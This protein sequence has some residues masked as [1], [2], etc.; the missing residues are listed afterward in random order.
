MALRHPLPIAG[1]RFSISLALVC[2]GLTSILSCRTSTLLSENFDK[3]PVAM[4]TAS[5]G[6]FHTVNG[7][8]VD[9]VGGSVFGSLCHPPASGNCIDLDGTGGK[10]Q[11]VLQSVNPFML[12]PGM[13]YY[14]SFNLIGSQRGN[15]T[16]TTVTF[17]P[18]HRTFVLASN[19]DSS[20]IVRSALVA[21]NVRTPAFLT[22][23]S[24]TPGEMG[25]VLDN[26]SITSSPSPAWWWLLVVLLIAVLIIGRRLR[27]QRAN[28]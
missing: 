15:T 6:A 23:T 8:N 16:S 2:L 26:V 27:R 5:A 17:G 9:L 4:A 21:V 18:Y 13:K 1:L 12:E 28:A 11:G 3:L 20:G 14:L 10:S 25:A 22:F 7:T 24:N 19:D